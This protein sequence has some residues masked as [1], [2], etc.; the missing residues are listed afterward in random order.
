MVK[1]RFR[2]RGMEFES[3]GN[4][5]EIKELI[6]R[7]VSEGYRT[8]KIFEGEKESLKEY[9]PD[10][11]TLVRFIL[12]KPNFEHNLF[13]V[14]EHFFG[15]KITSSGIDARRYN[16]LYRRLERARKKIER[17]YG[18]RFEAVWAR[19]EE[20]ELYKIFRFIKGRQPAQNFQAPIMDGGNLFKG[21]F[22]RT[23]M[24]GTLGRDV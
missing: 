4:I 16:A 8:E 12:S 13:E 17:D 9:I 22:K 5:E 20:G 19:G 1:L 14:A 7:L 10:Q 24:L 3:E 6:A 15:R 11:E 23:F 2:I 21:M 18:G